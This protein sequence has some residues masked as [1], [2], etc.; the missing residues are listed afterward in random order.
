METLILNKKLLRQRV[1][2]YYLNYA[3]FINQAVKK[4][5]SNSTTQK[6]YRKKFD[7]Q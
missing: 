7:T 5:S 2:D 3:S 6:K 1:N 4:I